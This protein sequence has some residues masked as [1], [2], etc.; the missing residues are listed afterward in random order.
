[1]AEEQKDR[2]ERTAA[3]NASARSGTAG[4]EEGA[5]VGEDEASA[6]EGSHFEGD[7]G[8]DDLPRRATAPDRSGESAGRDGEAGREGHGEYR[9]EGGY[10]FGSSLPRQ[11]DEAPGER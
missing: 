7:F 4:A 10:G 6:E 9:P 2:A 1:M 11:E 8:G 5:R 3:W